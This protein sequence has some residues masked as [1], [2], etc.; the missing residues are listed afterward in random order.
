MSAYTNFLNL[1]KWNPQEDTEEEFDIDKALNDNWDKI[2]LKLKDYIISVNDIIDSF[3]TDVNAENLAFKTQIE[4]EIN[5]LE[6]TVSSLSELINQTQSIHTYT[7]TI[8]ED[9]EKRCRN[10][11]VV[12]LQSSEMVACI[13]FNMKTGYY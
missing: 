2:D 11:I 4:N 13:K 10:R 12:L 8:V 3:K 6:S 1:F 5:A 7:M 9:T